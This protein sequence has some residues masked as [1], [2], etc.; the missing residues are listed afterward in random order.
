MNYENLVID[1][2]NKVC[3][4]NDKEINLN[5]KE[6][7]LLIYLLSKPN[8]IHS[9]ENII[10]DVWKKDVSIRTIDVNVMRLRKK[11]GKYGDNIYTRTGFGYGFKTR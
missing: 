10:K 4:I 5:R 1:E 11:L 7:E 2:D 8:Y 3:L 6:Y 9:R